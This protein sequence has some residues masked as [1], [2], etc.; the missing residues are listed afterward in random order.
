MR[1]VGGHGFRLRAGRR[2]LLLAA[3]LGLSLVLLHGAAS[4]ADGPT[5]QSAGGVYGYYWSPAS[6]E[7]S[8]GGSV[9]FNSASGSVEHGVTWTGG[10]EKPSCSG[11]PIDEGKTSWSGSCS[12]AQ[13]G[14]YSFYCPVHPT[15][16]KGTITA[17][18]GGAPPT[19][20][21]PPP[22]PQSAG[23]V[24]SDLTL[25]KRQRGG[26]VRGSVRLLRVGSGSRLEVELTAPR[27]RLFGPGHAGK[28][29]V[30]R[31]VRSS[32]AAGRFPIVVSLARVARGALHD[33]VALPVTVTVT[34]T[35][36]DGEVFKRTRGVLMGNGAAPV[37]QAR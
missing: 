6:V 21:P 36:P 10:P 16:M 30:G 11:V 15:E 18:A 13:A 8:A 33:E 1:R 7:V 17:T 26:T 23:A 34:V 20:S 35:S 4:L 2:R 28:M 27:L 3:P 5:I 24:A 32:P 12:F 25:A 31:L 19:G 9:T 14:T 37:R 29:R 22:G